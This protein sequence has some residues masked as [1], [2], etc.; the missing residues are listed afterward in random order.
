MKDLRIALPTL[1]TGGWDYLQFHRECLAY[2][3][4]DNAGMIFTSNKKKI[5]FILSYMKESTASSW[6]QNYYDIV[7]NNKGVITIVDNFE[8]FLKKL[9][10]SFKDPG[11]K[12]RA[13][14]R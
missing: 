10:Q 1:F 11:K 2:I 5:S 3:S 8:A 4:T 13:Y 9:D 6:A 7:M 12:D 14:K